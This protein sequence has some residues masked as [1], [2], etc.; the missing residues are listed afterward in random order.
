MNNE[1][2]PFFFLG[3]ELPPGKLE[4]MLPAADN[5]LANLN[6]KYQALAQAYEIARN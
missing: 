3:A 2:Y 4:H 5:K 6:K 1:H